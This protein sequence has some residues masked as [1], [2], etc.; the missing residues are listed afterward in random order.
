[1]Y[2]YVSINMYTF[3]VADIPVDLY[4]VLD[5]SSSMKTFSKKLAGASED[6]TDEIQKLTRDFRL[7][8]G[9]FIEKPRIPFTKGKISKAYAFHHIMNLT[10]NSA[11]EF[12]GKVDAQI[13][14][15]QTNIDI[16]EAGLDA[17]AQAMLCPQ[18]I[19]WEE[20]RKK[21]II[22]MT[23]AEMHFA[24]DGILGGITDKFPMKECLLDNGS[25]DSKQNDYDYPSFG[26]VISTILFFLNNQI[27][28]NPVWLYNRSNHT[29]MAGKCGMEKIVYSIIKPYRILD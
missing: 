20:D 16:P 21:I 9:S 7:G 4:F 2:L 29:V 14:T 8:F 11:K 26:Q 23:D 5:S 18:I 1:M 17:I 19:G 6:I 27:H 24:F 25:Y 28:D 12:K 3:Q 15:F 10:K 22:V 13:E